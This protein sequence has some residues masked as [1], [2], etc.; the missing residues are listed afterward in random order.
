MT[1]FAPKIYFS[2]FF[3][4]FALQR[5]EQIRVW[6]KFLDGAVLRSHL[7]GARYDVRFQLSRTMLYRRHYALS[8]CA[9]FYGRLL[10]GQGTGVGQPG[11]L[12]DLQFAN[13]SLNAHQQQ[14][15]RA[16]MHRVDHASTTFADSSPFIVFGP[17]GTGKTTTLVEALVQLAR[18]EELRVLV[19]VGRKIT[20]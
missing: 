3:L 4:S 14:A 2:V 18:R 6:L 10:T 13:S 9:S 8:L 16:I 20:D 7:P 1:S 5:V 11:E 15:V 12:P 17:P 19:H